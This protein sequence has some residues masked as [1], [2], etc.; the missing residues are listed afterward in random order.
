MHGTMTLADKRKWRKITL[1]KV[2]PETASL[3]DVRARPRR[4]GVQ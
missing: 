4:S 1:K 2:R 3:S